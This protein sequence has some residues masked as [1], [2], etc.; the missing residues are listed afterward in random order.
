MSN[1]SP[2][3]DDKDGPSPKKNLK[4]R[5]DDKELRHSGPKKSGG[6]VIQIFAVVY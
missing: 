6:S 1:S 4:K 3:D 2:S 5:G